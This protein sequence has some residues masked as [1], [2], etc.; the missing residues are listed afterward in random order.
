MFCGP[1]KTFFQGLLR[2]RLFWCTSQILCGSSP[3]QTRRCY[4]RAWANV[5]ALVEQRHKHQAGLRTRV[6]NPVIGC[7]FS[8]RWVGSACAP[9]VRGEIGDTERREREKES[10]RESAREQQ[11][12]FRLNSAAHSAAH[13]TKERIVRLRR[14]GPTKVGRHA[15]FETTTY[16]R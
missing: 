14:F 6:S 13:V 5:D 15:P 8:I 7:N 10:T 2:S 3:L 4:F 9:V 16:I 1:T 12:A 11:S